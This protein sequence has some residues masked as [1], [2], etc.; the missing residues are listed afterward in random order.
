MPSS[1]TLE[2]RSRLDAAELFDRSLSIDAHVA[3][4]SH[5]DEVAIGGVT[6]GTIT[7]G[8][9]VTWHARHLGIRWTMTVQ[10]S[11][12]DRPIRFVDQQ[13]RGPFRLFV[14]EHTFTPLTDGC[15]MTDTLT[16]ASPVFGALADVLAGTHQ[17]RLFRETGQLGR[18][19]AWSRPIVAL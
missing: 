9:T 5:T 12:L 10:I 1:F 11:A 15:L 18:E 19:V 8:E 6:T 17:V 13:I 2:T 16:V 4:M 3:S 14:H 7:E